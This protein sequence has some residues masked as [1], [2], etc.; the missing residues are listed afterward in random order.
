M[1]T[2]KI[3]L[4]GEEKKGNLKI[5][6]C[7]DYNSKEEKK[8]GK[9]KGEKD[10]RSRNWTFIA[11][12]KE[13][14]EKIRK[15]FTEEAKNIKVAISPMHIPDDDDQHEKIHWHI[16]LVFE[17][18]KSYEQV[19]K[20][21]EE[22]GCNYPLPIGTME[23]SAFRDLIEATRYLTHADCPFRKRT[24]EPREIEGING[25]EV[26]EL[27]TAP[28]KE[29][30]KDEDENKILK[31][32]RTYGMKNFSEATDFIMDEYPYLLPAFKRSRTLFRDYTNSMFYKSRLQL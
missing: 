28:I 14:V 11:W 3:A 15:F 24:Y 30:I 23:R 20:S 2:K 16:I 9:K 13:T 32:M 21:I 5:H 4:L 7:K 1:E 31:I 17:N 29:R 12:S 6:L 10:R 26:E 8:Q 25:Y 22:F 19:E 27:F 18:K